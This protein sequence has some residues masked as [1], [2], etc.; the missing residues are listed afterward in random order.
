MPRILEQVISVS[1]VSIDANDHVNNREYLRWMEDVAIAHS[2][3]QGWPMGRYVELGSTWYVRSHYVEYIRPARAGM[4]VTALTW[5]ATME[6]SSTLRRYAFLCEGR[7]LAT[8]ETVWVFVDMRTGRPVRVPQD[9]REA[10]PLVAAD[11][12]GLAVLGAG[13]TARTG[14]ERPA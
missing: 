1:E 14:R 13:G 6:G 3:V 9:V 8:A 10:F 11:D 5:V 12:P 2:T 4:A 7:L